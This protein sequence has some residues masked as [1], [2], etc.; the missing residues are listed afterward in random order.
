MMMDRRHLEHAL[1]GQLER[2]HLHD[3]AQRLHH[4]QAADDGEHDLV[5]DDDRDRP[6]QAAERQRT[7][8]AHENLRRRRVEPEE[9]DARADHRAADDDDLAGVGDVVD[10]Q[11]VRIDEIAGE[12]GDEPERRRG[13]HH[14]HDGQPVEPV[15]Q[16]DRVA[17]GDDDERTE[18]QEAPAQID[19]VAVDEGQRERR[20]RGAADELHRVDTRSPR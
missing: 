9:A 20:R 7:G 2:G 17:E 8:V 5:L 15:G 10:E 14:R 16:I 19:H 6:E 4:E 3:D 18:Q 1:A 13:D 11:I 12:I